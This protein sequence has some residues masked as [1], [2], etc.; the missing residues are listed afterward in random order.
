MSIRRRIKLETRDRK[1]VLEEAIISQ[2]EFLEKFL[3]RPRN[4][5]WFLFDL[6]EENICFMWF[7]Q[8]PMNN[9]E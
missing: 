1:E 9:S 3:A 2:D 5:H 4:F 8:M 6:K 7:I